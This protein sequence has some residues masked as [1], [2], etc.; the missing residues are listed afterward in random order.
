MGETHSLAIRHNMKICFDAD[1]ETIPGEN[2]LK[3]QE[4]KLWC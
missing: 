4:E 1:N 2:L 3:I